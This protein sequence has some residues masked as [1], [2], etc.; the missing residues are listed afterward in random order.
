MSEKKYRFSRRD[1]LKGLVGLPFLGYFANRFYVQHKNAASKPKVD[2]SKY[3][4][5]E[6]DPDIIPA[7]GYAAKGDKIRLGVVA[8]GGRGPAIFRG[9]GFAQEDWASRYI[10]NGSPTSLLKNFL[11]QE[12]LNIEVTGICDTYTGRA[13]EAVKATTTTFRAGGAPQAKAPTNYPTYRDMLKDDQLDAIIILAP[14]HLHAEMAIAAAKAGKHI[15]L[16]K[17]MCQ[18]IEEAKALRDMVK[19]TGILLQVGHQN[20]QQASYMKAK[21]MVRKDLLGPVSLIETFTNRNS[22]SGAW[23]RGIPED[24][25]ESNTNW[26]EFLG[27]KPWREFDPDM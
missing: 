9:L 17:P 20:R 15:Y 11:D 7:T 12:D 25:N 19:K 4:I 23:I 5:S 16:E 27:N 2:W 14:D 6:Y 1:V 21:E 22:D 3:G 26:K 10:K 8:F 24:A 13:E 18:T